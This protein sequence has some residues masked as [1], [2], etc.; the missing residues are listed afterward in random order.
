M[1]GRL[2]SFVDEMKVVRC[3]VGLLIRM[4]VYLSQEYPFQDPNVLIQLTVISAETADLSRIYSDDLA[5]GF[6]VEQ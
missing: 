1:F 4:I 5:A 6:V 3:S 2:A